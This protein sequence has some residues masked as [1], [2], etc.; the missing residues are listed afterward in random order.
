MDRL[1][2]LL[3]DHARIQEVLLFPAMRRE[4]RVGE[5]EQR[6]DRRNDKE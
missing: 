2:M 5:K 6:A 4:E 1:V 3:A